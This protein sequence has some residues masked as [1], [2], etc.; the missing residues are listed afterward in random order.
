MKKFLKKI[1]NIVFLFLL[2]FASIDT[3]VADNVFTLIEK[4]FDNKSNNINEDYNFNKNARNFTKR[5]FK[6][7][8]S[9]YD[10]EIYL[11]GFG[12]GNRMRNQDVG[13]GFRRK[14]YS[15]NRGRGF[16][17]GNGLRCRYSMANYD[18]RENWWKERD[19]EREERRKYN[20]ENGLCYKTP[21]QKEQYRAESQRRREMNRNR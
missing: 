2:I 4:D 8:N 11:I 20:D 17:K 12:R 9:L 10:N 16:G 3:C 19:K 7:D 5:R 14:G 13:Y 18:A 15:L 21:E 6:K 1:K